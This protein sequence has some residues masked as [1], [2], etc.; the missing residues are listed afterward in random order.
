MT[1]SRGICRPDSLYQRILYGLLNEIIVI[2]VGDERTE[3]Q[4]LF[5]LS[6]RLIGIG[7]G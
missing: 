3:N 7:S 6:L 2:V 5:L 4:F 1:L